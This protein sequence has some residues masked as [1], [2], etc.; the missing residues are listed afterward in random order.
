MQQTSVY[1]YPAAAAA[2]AAAAAMLL[3]S[4]LTLQLYQI[5]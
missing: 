4:C 1:L 2:A 5:H 3:Q